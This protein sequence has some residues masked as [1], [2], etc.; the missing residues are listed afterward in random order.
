MF[1]GHGCG[2]IP[3]NV[4]YCNHL[5][6]QITPTTLWG[7]VYY[8]APFANRTSYTIKIL[9][10]Y[11]STNINIYCNNTRKFYTIN[12]GGFVNETLS[13]HKYCAIHSNKKVLV[14][15]FSHGEN[16]YEAIG[17]PTMTLVPSTNQY[18]N[19]FGFSTL[20][21]PSFNHSINVIVTSQYYQPHM[22]S[23]IAGGVT[24]SLAAQQWVPIRVNNRTE[25]YATQVNI[26]QGITKVL[27]TDTAAEMMVIVYG[28]SQ[29]DGYG[30]IGGIHIAAGSL[31]HYN[32]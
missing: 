29:G 3:W 25:A 15:Q 20:H 5:I 6:E 4:A 30:H 27:H 21:N 13:M 22:I 14:T 11:N 31:N 28:F 23:V 17:D 32:Y 12:E 2:N 8:T 26:P 16:Y 9:A 19:Q 1:S 10:A 7:I 18:L 24:R